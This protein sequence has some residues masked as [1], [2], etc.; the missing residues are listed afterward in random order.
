VVATRYRE[1]TIRDMACLGSMRFPREKP[2][3]PLP[4]GICGV[5]MS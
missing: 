4:A 2:E 5:L 3:K 1:I